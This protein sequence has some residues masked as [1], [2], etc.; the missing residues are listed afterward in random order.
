MDATK[1]FDPS[2]KSDTI[3]R[4]SD[5]I[6]FFV[7]GPL[8]S[9]VSPVFDDMLSSSIL[10]ENKTKHGLPIVDIAEDSDTLRFLL[11]LIYPQSVEPE[12]KFTDLCL[13]VCKA[14]QKY[15]MEVIES[16][17]QRILLA[18]QLIVQEP[19]RIYAIAVPLRWEKIAMEAARI[20]LKTPLQ[21]LTYATELR[22]ISG[23]DFY[24]YLQFRFR[25]DRE[26]GEVESSSDV[27]WHKIPMPIS[28]TSSEA[29]IKT[30]VATKPFDSAAEADVILRSSDHVDFYVLKA[31]L[32]I[33]S[34][35]FDAILSG[36]R[37][38]DEKNDPPLIPVP[39]SS[40]A[41]RQLLRLVYH[42]VEELDIT[43][44]LCMDVCKAA[45]RYKM[46]TI[47]ARL[48]K[49]MVTSSLMT[50]EPLQIYALASAL[51][52]KEV[53]RMAAMITLNKLVEDLPYVEELARISGADLYCLIEYRFECIGVVSRLLDVIN[54]YELLHNSRI[55]TCPSRLVIDGVPP[56]FSQYIMKI[57]QKLKA[58]PR[59]STVMDVADLAAAI[60]ELDIRKEGQMTMKLLQCRRILA[61][62][63]DDAV[64]KV[65]IIGQFYIYERH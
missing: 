65:T 21:D 20:S 30:T 52:W 44:G 48:R 8:L 26:Q 37:N 7:L 18:S 27:P 5:L 4:S 10:K 51:G 47:E 32:R 62:A 3:L 12:L 33:V 56:W 22:L 50:H 43:V 57:S 15:R 13:K 59:A 40:K 35:V 39:E 61:T 34:P 11:L 23:A 6:D 2:A 36:N 17:V 31:L 46:K 53:A 38:V 24:H 19:L 64:S 42:H 9:L 63:V 14:T 54:Q 58:R 1:P 16:K 41:L 25:R 45:Q 55:V 29:K 60:A 49:Q 28:M